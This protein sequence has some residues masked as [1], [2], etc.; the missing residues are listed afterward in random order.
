MDNALSGWAIAPTLNNITSRL[1]CIQKI[2]D[3][4]NSDYNPLISFKR[5]D[6]QGCYTITCQDKSCTRTLPLLEKQIPVLN[7]WLSLSHDP[8]LSSYTL[9]VEHSKMIIDEIDEIQYPINERGS[10][11][12]YISV[13][14]LS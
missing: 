13:H 12:H 2:L 10:R 7:Q 11:S 5:D 14:A 3:D 1:E 4:H 9:C 6:T 8:N